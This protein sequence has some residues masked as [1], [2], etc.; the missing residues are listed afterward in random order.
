VER[1]NRAGNSSN[2]G[3]CFNGMGA[4]WTSEMGDTNDPLAKQLFSELADEIEVVFKSIA[5]IERSGNI[6]Y[7]KAVYHCLDHVQKG[8]TI[9][10]FKPLV[11]TL[12]YAGPSRRKQRRPIDL[13]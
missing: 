4:K 9:E 5:D 12:T 13:H 8:G 6:D 3:D 2:M 7:L 11:R 10:T 1:N